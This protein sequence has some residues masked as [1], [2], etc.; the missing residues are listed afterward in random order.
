MR[1]AKI[2]ELIAANYVADIELSGVSIDSRSIKKQELFV[3]IKGENFDGHNYI[4][5]AESAGAAAIVCE[6][7]VENVKIPQ[8]IV[9]DS[10]K[11]LAE[12]A[13]YH[14]QSIDCTVIALTGSN[15]KTTVKEMISHILPEP[16]F[17]TLGNLNNHIGVPLCALKLKSEHKFAVFELGANHKGEIAN[18]VDI[19]EPKVVLINNI[20]PAHI[21][22]F[23]SI[24]GV[25]NAKGEIYQGVIPSGIA[26]VN[27]DDAYAHY[28]DD[29]LADKKVVRFSI[30]KPAD[31]YADKIILNKQGFAS[32][33]LVTP[34]GVLSIQLKVA[35]LHNVSNAL[36]AATCTYSA[37]ISLERIAKGLE[38]FSGVEGRITFKNGRKK[39]VIIDDTYNANL[40]SVLTALDVLSARD[41]LRILV[42]GDMG[43]LGDFTTEHHKEIGIAAH[44]SGIER[45]LTC[46]KY[47]KY[48]AE[49]FGKDGK[50]YPDQSTLISDLISHLNEK[51]T[52]LVKGSRL[53]A[54]E[55]IVQEL[56]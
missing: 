41:G 47:S 43:E 31:I 38:N 36:A 23:G 15:G 21:E 40:R 33:Q 37:G 13:K 48:A 1:L 20:A 3:A 25:A 55:K 12:I 29:I 16:F 39:S 6:R 9:R 19:V 42:L 2:A 35:G 27:D 54:M 49:A 17:A 5:A 26:V 18:I 44:K 24:D 30:E 32:F 14:R 11:A 28:W 4:L 34:K 52:V 22:G 7:L 46:G 56:I 45:V 50:H 51:T 10:I 53:A 8:L